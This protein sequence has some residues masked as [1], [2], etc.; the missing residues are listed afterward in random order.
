MAAEP[1]RNVMVFR[2]PVTSDKTTGLPIDTPMNSSTY[3]VAIDRG[4]LRLDG[5]TI[6]VEAVHGAEES[7]NIRLEDVRAIE[8]SLIKSPSGNLKKGKT[9]FRMKGR[10]DQRRGWEDY[11]FKM[12]VVDHEWL[13][14]EIRRIT[15]RSY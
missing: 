8:L 15:G 9:V 7:V 2:A 10:I 13:H 12:D 3:Y 4:V 1:I 6:I 11:C 14:N 5:F